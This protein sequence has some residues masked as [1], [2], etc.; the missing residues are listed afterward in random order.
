MAE[1]K[2]TPVTESEV[3]NIRVSLDLDDGSTVECKI[4]TIFEAAGKEYIALLPLDE[5]GNENPS[6]DVYLYR[7]AEDDK[8]IP[9]VE[10][11]DDEDEYE[12]AADRFDE[13]L[14]EALYDDMED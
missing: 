12:A 9:S 14:D 1:E 3:D 4:I 6:G 11:I 8:G 13:M 7:Y 5:K 2:I 10:Y